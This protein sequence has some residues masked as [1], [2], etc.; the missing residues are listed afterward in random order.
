[1]DIYHDF[2]IHLCYK[3]APAPDRG[4]HR[5]KGTTLMLC[6]QSQLL[7]LQAEKSGRVKINIIFLE[8]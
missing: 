1:M 3:N 5:M 7:G 4:W 6:W 2:S 8:F